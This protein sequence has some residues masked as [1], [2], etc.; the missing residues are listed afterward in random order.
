MAIG[1]EELSK[2]QVT[3]PVEGGD[4]V[5]KPDEM[6]VG[7]AALLNKM[8]KKPTPGVF[9]LPEADN[10]MPSFMQVA[11][12]GIKEDTTQMAGGDTYNVMAGELLREGFEPNYIKS[13]DPISL[14]QLY[15]QTF[16]SSRDAE[17][18][19]EV[20][21]TDWRTI[22]KM[23]QSGMSQE[24]IEEQLAMK[25]AKDDLHMKAAAVEDFAPPDHQLAY[26]TPEEGDILQLLGGSGDFNKMTGVQT[27]RIDK[28]DRPDAD[29]INKAK[30]ER[31]AAKAQGEQRRQA[32]A[33]MASQ[34]ISGM[35]GG[36]TD[37]E[38]GKKARE[39]QRD[40]YTD[41]GQD[42]PDYMK[43]DPRYEEEVKE[44]IIEKIGGKGK[45][46]IGTLGEHLTI[47]KLAKLLDGAA[48]S[49]EEGQVRDLLK[50]L[51]TEEAAT[52][53][54]NLLRA[55][56]DQTTGGLSDRGEEWFKDRGDLADE[57][58]GEHKQ[59][60]WADMSDEEKFETMISKMKAGG[61]KQFLKNFD[62]DAYWSEN[63]PKTAQ[64][65]KDMAQAHKSGK[66]TMNRDNTVLIE[67]GRKLLQEDRP[68]R[69][70]GGGGGRR[71]EEVAE[72]VDDTT[73]TPD[74]R[75][76]AFNVGGTM[77]YTHDT[78]TAGVEMNVPLG[79][80][81]EIDKAGKF[82]GT[83]GMSADEAFKY[84][85]LGG[86]GQL[87][88]FQEYLTRRRKHLGEEP[89]EYFDEEGNVIYSSKA[90]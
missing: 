12:E 52:G 76:G 81:F 28:E 62:P 61:G 49:W 29:K 57:V 63:P 89:P 51:G 40:F 56:Q 2:M 84:A 6:P 25:A 86:Y 83:T 26:I 8:Q 20:E 13:L 90:T 78:R 75:A 79:R 11:A 55:M 23:I 39:I 73:I 32:Y 33:D 68:T 44:T 22:L 4:M 74:E 9:K 88:P 7:A 82:R 36:T 38:A 53:W 17:E 77:P 67:Q 21:P 72:V 46:L 58:L 50:T 30:Q 60:G 15:E 14:H 1:I 37:T 10:T 64:D 45:D 71:V 69:D 5:A 87:E 24:E 43:D 65:F 54:G 66:L 42:V 35:A 47:G 70:S 41:R 3:G 31:I 85:T 34:G 18:M 27:F 80:R 48:S 16:G 19:T 59:T